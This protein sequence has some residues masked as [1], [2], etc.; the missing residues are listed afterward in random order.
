MGAVICTAPRGRQITCSEALECV[1]DGFEGNEAQGRTCQL[2]EPQSASSY[3]C[4]DVN[5]PIP[6]ADHFIEYI[7]L[8]FA[9]VEPTR[10]D[11]PRVEVPF[12]RL[13]P[14]DWHPSGKAQ[15]TNYC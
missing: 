11:P 15:I 9:S 7:E 3:F 8:W 13:L 2:R 10:S 4:A 12:Q 6:E 1:G 5:C 14:I